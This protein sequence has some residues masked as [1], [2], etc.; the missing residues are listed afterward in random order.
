[1]KLTLKADEIPEHLKEY[2]RPVK[3][4]QK[5]LFMI[6]ERFAWGMIQ[7]GWILRAKIVWHKP[8]G[9]IESSK[10]RPKLDY[11]MLY[12]FS[13]D[14]HYWFNYIEAK[15]PLKTVTVKRNK[16]A[17]GTSGHFQ[18]LHEAENDQVNFMP[19][20]GGKKH[21]DHNGNPTYSGNKMK[22]HDGMAKIGSVWG[23]PPESIWSITP[24]TFGHEYCETCDKLVKSRQLLYKCQDCGTVY[25]QLKAT[26]IAIKNG[27]DPETI[28]LTCGR[29]LKRHISANAKDRV[30]GL[31]PDKIACD[32]IDIPDL[33]IEGCPNCKSRKRDFVCPI[34]KIKVHMHFAMFPEELV[35]PALR[36]TCPTEVCKKCGQPRYPVYTPTEEYAK[37]LSK[38]WHDH[39]DDAQA[40]QMQE[41]VVP[42]AVAD[43]RISSWT[44][45]ECNIEFEPG[46]IMDVFAGFNTV[47]AVAMK[48]G[49][50]FLGIE[51]DPRNVK[52]GMK[53]VQ[54]MPVSKKNN[55]KVGLNQARL[56]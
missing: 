34:C 14:Q 49:R 39:S 27:L 30:E 29:T 1:M 43:Y 55:V 37:M 40:G 3:V 44:K 17:V 15:K 36:M 21:S 4:Q 2:F 24:K 38:G 56:F 16:Y 50:N 18:A 45:C 13:K 7:R 51:L 42:A 26:D 25:E 9:M 53:R 48:N 22:V 23:L 10:D 35:L 20:I 12:M 47:G 46:V 19:A 8:N 33:E 52:A 31:K 11:E 41:K 28:C 6:P 32:G 54:D 5:S